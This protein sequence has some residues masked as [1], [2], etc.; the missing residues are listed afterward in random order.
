M[1]YLVL[2]QE[3]GKQH[4]QTTIVHNPPDINSAGN[5]RHRIGVEIDAFGDEQG[6]LSSRHVAHCIQEHPPRPLIRGVAPSVRP[7]QDDC[8]WL[9]AAQT[10]RLNAVEGGTVLLTG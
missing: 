2:A 1:T 10:T 6:H 3:E 8:V 4:E 9:H 7:A 5:L